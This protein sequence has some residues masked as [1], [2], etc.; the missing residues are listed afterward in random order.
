MSL[1]RRPLA[2]LGGEILTPIEQLSERERE[3]L[4]RPLL[5]Y[6]ARGKHG[7][8]HE[9][10]G[11][12]IAF[13]GGGWC[14]LLYR[15]TGTGRLAGS[16]L[17]VKFTMRDGRDRAGREHG[18]LRALDETGLD[19]APRTVLLDR[20]SYSQPVVVQTWLQ[21]ETSEDPPLA[22]EEWQGL[23]DHLAMVHSVTPERIGVRL[24]RA[25]LDANSVAEARGTVRWQMSRIPHEARPAS[26][27]KLL[28]RFEAAEYPAWREPRVALCRVDNNVRNYVR[29]P[30]TWASVDWEYSGW[31]DPAFDVA[32]WAT[33][34]SYTDVSLS[35]WA[36]V[37]DAYCRRFAKQAGI[38]DPTLALR[39]KVYV[40]VMSVW[41]VARVARYLYEI[42][43][44]LD[45][46]LV[47]WPE[48]WEANMHGKYEH[49]LGL[50]NL[51]LSEG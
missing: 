5:D 4:L 40:Q 43:A 34:A 44:G 6:L 24:P 37:L 3:R 14:N 41:W 48:D 35:C 10:E 45:R 36:W 11:W 2:H 17:A 38:D 47:P 13:I 18:A 25:V 15:A 51:Y 32:Q 33:H 29:R 19:L 39:I 16:D 8:S 49:Y 31:G 12:Q 1:R 27:Q 23:L 21:G 42:P 9:W 26:L 30:G 22:D 28:R 50:A 20:D 46:R 7:T